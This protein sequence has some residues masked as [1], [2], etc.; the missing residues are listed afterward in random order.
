[1]KRALPK[2]PLDK[3]DQLMPGARE[4]LMPGGEP[5]DDPTVTVVLTGPG[6]EDPFDMGAANINAAVTQHWA[7]GD[8]TRVVIYSNK[9]S[10]FWSNVAVTMTAA[11]GTWRR[12]LA[13]REAR[14]I[15]TTHTGSTSRMI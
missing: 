14:V 7:E 10:D 6:I 4:L 5:V 3:L 1:M 15:V 12:G 2:D 8:S 11:A 9:N 13:A